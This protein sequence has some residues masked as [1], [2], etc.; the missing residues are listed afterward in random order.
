V[1][2]HTYQASKQDLLHMLKNRFLKFAEF[3]STLSNEP[4][5]NAMTLLFDSFDHFFSKRSG[6][7]LVFKFTLRFSLPTKVPK[8]K[9]N[10]IR[11]MYGR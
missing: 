1:A 11:D 10:L 4:G 3:A 5:V 8:F 9:H 6:E 7:F 2:I